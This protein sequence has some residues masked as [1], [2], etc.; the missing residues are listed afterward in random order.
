MFSFYGAKTKI[1]RYYPSPKFDRIIEP[2]A[3]SAQYS[4]KYPEHDV[5]LIE[6]DPCLARIWQW[7]IKDCTVQDLKQLPSLKVGDDLRTMKQLSEVEKD[8]LGFAVGWGRSTPGH[9]VTARAD[10][11][12]LP[13]SDPQWRRNNAAS[14]LISRAIDYLPKIKHWKIIEGC[15]TSCRYNPKSTWFIDPP[16]QGRAGRYYKCDEI[17]YVNL[18]RYCRD[19]RG[20]VIVCEGTEGTWLPFVQIANI[21]ETGLRGPLKEKVWIREEE[22]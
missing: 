4:L 7:L 2:F 13:K 20:Q 5:T 8:F 3:G 17:D 15:Y 22:K 1:L 11:T 9:I 12:S 6:R 21:T 14:L 10:R 19:R 16:Y 18:A